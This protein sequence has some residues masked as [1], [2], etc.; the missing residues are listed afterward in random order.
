MNARC[1]FPNTIEYKFNPFP[2]SFPTRKGGQGE[3][4]GRLFRCPGK[5]VPEPF[6][7]RVVLFRQGRERPWKLLVWQMQN[8]LRQRERLC[9]KG[10]FRGTGRTSK[11]QRGSYWEE[12][13]LSIF[14]PGTNR[15]ESPREKKKPQ[16]SIGAGSWPVRRGVSHETFLEDFLPIPPIL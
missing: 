2:Y 3:S 7:L 10:L 13:L 15:G 4:L 16:F 9:K 14:G 5:R 8:F 11:I 1:A 12:G 6:G